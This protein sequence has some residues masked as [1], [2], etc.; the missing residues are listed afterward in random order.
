[1]LK[2]PLNIFVFSDVHLGHRRTPTELIVDNIK[3][4]LPD[5]VRSDKIDMIIIP[6]DLFDRFL[7]LPQDDTY[8]IHSFIGW[9]LILCKKRNI[10]LRVL[11]G[12][13]SHDW[14]QPKLI[15]QINDLVGADA[16]HMPMLDIEHIDKFDI[17]VLY[18]P[19][20]WSHDNDDTWCQV[21]RLLIE[22]QLEKVDFTV[23][24]GQFAYQLPSHVD[25][26][27]HIPERYSKITR[28][29]VFCGHVH[30][31]SKKYNIIVPGSFDR[32]SHNEEHPKG[33][34]LVNV[35]PNG[36][37][38]ILFIEN[39]NAMTYMTID[40]VGLDINDVLEKV[41]QS[42]KDCRYG[43][44]I[45][46]AAGVNDPISTSIGV[47]SDKYP[48]LHFESHRSEKQKSTK[49]TLVDMR[50]KYKSVPITPTSVIE[51]I[52]DELTKHGVNENNHTPY[53][54]KLREVL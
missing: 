1:M 46:I 21:Q 44:R 29:Y 41:E 6:G 38:T 37:D 8:Q 16:K 52:K 12:T 13:P 28:H 3:S 19:D 40:C 2:N 7:N 20:E 36:D 51:L 32:L 11:E 33:A 26:P 50:S 4:V 35:N 25:A 48:G 45:R 15:D 54:E 53:L 49:E 17:D 30:I 5:D 27:V 39:I 23:M 24:H 34:W 10:V 18:I 22:R 42:V 47:L 31:P 43:S 9:L 14:K